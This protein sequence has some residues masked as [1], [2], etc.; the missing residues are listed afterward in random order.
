MVRNVLSRPIFTFA[1][2]AALVA[3]V[4]AS[5]GDRIAAQADATHTDQRAVAAALDQDPAFSRV[6]PSG[7]DGTGTDAGVF[8]PPLAGPNATVIGTV[9]DPNEAGPK[10]FYVATVDGRGH[11]T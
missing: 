3:L 8:L 10:A 5:N 1:L 9:E 6:A 7:G 4:L 2:L 11:Q